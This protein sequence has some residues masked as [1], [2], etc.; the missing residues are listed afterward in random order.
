MNPHQIDNLLPLHQLNYMAPIL[1]IRILRYPE[2]TLVDFYRS[3]VY[4]VLIVYGTNEVIH[5]SMS[6]T[7]NNMREWLFGVVTFFKNC[8]PAI[9]SNMYLS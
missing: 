8:T 7:K 9:L 4:L 6:Y 3:H 5:T 1:I 2:C